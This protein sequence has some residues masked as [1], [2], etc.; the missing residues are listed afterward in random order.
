MKV[1][2]VAPSIYPVLANKEEIQ[3]IGGAELQQCY[4]GRG[5]IDKGYSVFYVSMDYGQPDGEELNGLVVLKTYKPA[6]GIF[7]LRFFYP[8]LHTTWKALK[9]ANA[10]IYIVR[11]DTYLLGILSVFCR[12]YKKKIIFC[13]AHDA[14]FI[15]NQFRMKTK[16][17]MVKMRDK[18]L[19]LYGL[20]RADSIIVQ[21]KL[22]KKLLWDNF[23]LKSN[24]IRNFHPSKPVKLPV[25]QRKYILWVA[26]MRAWKRPGQFINLARA[27]PQEQFIMIGG[28]DMKDG[29]LYDEINEQAEKLQNLQFLGF[30][31]LRV[32]ETYFNKCKVFINTSKYEGF[33]NTFLQAWRRGIPV[34]SYVDPDDVIQSNNL[35]RVVI[36]EKDLYGALSDILSNPYLETSYIHNYFTLNHSEETINKYC[37]LFQQIIQQN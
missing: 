18:Y 25:S 7:G 20:R 14:N 34:I 37:S 32:T 22:Q 13:A 30:Q 19:Y 17:R 5:L 29:Y 24:I 11:S 3:I 12:L 1:C 21:S 15:P 2:F 26:T 4:I 10:D 9:K 33:P 6:E 23:N 28:R 35:G 27:F 31:P 36:S 16:Y 8:R